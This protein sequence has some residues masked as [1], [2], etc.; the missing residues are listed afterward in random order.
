MIKISNIDAFL[1]DNELHKVD[2]YLQGEKIVKICEM[3][4]EC[5]H[6][7]MNKEC[8]C[9]EANEKSAYSEE[10]NITEI[11]GDGMILLPGF[12]DTHFHGA[13][14]ADFSDGT[15]DALEKILSYE[16]QH[17]ITSV[18]PAT[19]TLPNEELHH[20]CKLTKEYQEK[21]RQ[22]REVAE[23]L[24]IY[25][26]G[27]FFSKEK[28]G[29]QRIDC[30]QLPN[31]ELLKELQ[32][33]SGNLIKVCAL[34][35]ELEG[36]FS[37]IEEA[38]RLYQD[39]LK[40]SLGHTTA[41]A[42]TVK[43]ALDIGAERL[44]H[45]YNAMLH[46]EEIG[47]LMAGLNSGYAELICDG[48]HNSKARVQGAFEMFGED[49]VI[50]ISDSMRAVGL[51]DGTYTLGGQEVEVLGRDAFLKNKTRAGSVCNL[52]DCFRTA[53]ALGVSFR[54][55]VKAV[56]VNPAKAL[57][58]QDRLGIIKLGHQADL[59]I[60]NQQLQLQLVIKKGFIIK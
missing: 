10:E 49:R 24:G 2:V 44:T 40:I 18:C 3:N 32:E 25:M 22:N 47:R 54:E 55:A 53:I 21:N 58:V 26:E 59:L 1:E 5:A 33:A 28:C 4:E 20:I 45:F 50:L 48:V 19:M 51:P 7:E 36:A 57:G 11:T 17:G 29:A 9:G 52:L 39:D 23:L 12:I 15:E 56:T 43:K 13:M 38:K 16:I 46:Y 6:G 27:P 8:T 31:I 14:G 41:D 35:P 60:L 30:L 42:G 37:F 34:A